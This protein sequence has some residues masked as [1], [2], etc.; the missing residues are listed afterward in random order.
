MKITKPKKQLFNT[1]TTFY[2][3][4]ES[5]GDKHIVVR[6]DSAFFDCKGSTYFCDCKDFMTRKLPL[7][8]TNLFSLCK[9]GSFV[10]SNQ[11]TQPAKPV[12]GFPKNAYSKASAELVQ[13]ASKKPVSLK[14]FGVFFNQLGLCEVPRIS[15]CRS[16]DIPET[17][18]TKQEAQTAIDKA[19]TLVEYTVQEIKTPKQFAVYA[20]R[21]D[22]T[23]YRSSDVPG[24]FDNRK[25]ARLALDE[26][27]LNHSISNVEREVRECQN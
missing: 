3:S 7:Y 21:E 2:V 13:P 10:R 8:G 4:S 6:K 12:S 17:F 22:G 5:G 11:E 24:I 26:F 25:A 14:K 27:Y 1:S 19:G 16:N 15:M 20:I 18:S 9:H 23:V